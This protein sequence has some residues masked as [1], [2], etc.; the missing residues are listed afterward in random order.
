MQFIENNG[1]YLTQNIDD[2]PIEERVFFRQGVGMNIDSGI[3]RE[4]TP[5]ELAEWKEWQRRESEELSELM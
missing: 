1:V 4:A 2:L 5:Q 3:Y